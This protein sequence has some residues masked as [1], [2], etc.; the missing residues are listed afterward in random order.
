MKIRHDYILDHVQV[1][2]WDSI[3]KAYIMF[4]KNSI[5]F[6]FLLYKYIN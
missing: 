6:S 2:V 1:L 3:Y 5:K 4:K